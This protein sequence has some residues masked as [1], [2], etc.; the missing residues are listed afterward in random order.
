M[1]CLNGHEINLR[2]FQIEPDGAVYP[3]V[4]C[5]TSGCNF[6]RFVLLQHCPPR[7]ASRSVSHNIH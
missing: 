4:V 7:V 3:R 2:A 1:T 5:G 6:E